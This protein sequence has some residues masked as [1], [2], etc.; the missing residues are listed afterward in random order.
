MRSRATATPPEQHG[1]GT[2]MSLMGRPIGPVPRSTR[3]AVRRVPDVS[4]G[5]RDRPARRPRIRASRRPGRAFPRTTI[6]DQVALKVSARRRARHRALVHGRR[7]VDG[8]DARA[9]VGRRHARSA[10]PHG[11]RISV[12]AQ[13]T[14]EQIALSSVQMR[15]IR[16]DR[17]CGAV[18]TT[19][20]P[21]RRRPH[22]GLSIARIGQI[23]YRTELEL[24]ARFGRNHQRVRTRCSVGGTR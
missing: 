12:G 19:T 4:S 6:R 14:A 3:P 18:A 24:A 20:T 2:A 13:A 5:A 22:V 21:S 10:L 16:A 9:R 23:G 8:R 1:P 15:A 7:R 17:K 11:R